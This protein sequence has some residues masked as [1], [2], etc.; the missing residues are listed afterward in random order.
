MGISSANLESL[1]PTKGKIDANVVQESNQSHTE[2][3]AAMQL[4]LP[5]M[6]S[7]GGNHRTGQTGRPTLGKGLAKARQ[8]LRQAKGGWP[9][10]TEEGQPMQQLLS[11]MARLFLHHEDELN[12][13]AQEQEFMVFT[14]TG[15]KGMVPTMLKV[16]Q[17][18][19]QKVEDK[20][21]TR[22]PL[23]MVMITVLFKELELCSQKVMQAIQEG[24]MLRAELI[25]AKL[26]SEDGQRWKQV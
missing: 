24:Q 6:T 19:R 2:L 20:A 16:S 15:D 18:W 26:M 7:A 12:A 8:G 9:A 10:L 5:S 25:K 22:T 13:R 17:H 14:Q 11:S 3:M 1:E 23:R 4:L 21:N